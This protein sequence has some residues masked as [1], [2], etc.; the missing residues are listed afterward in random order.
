MAL[1]INIDDLLNKQKIE[2]NR[3]EFKRGWNPDKIYHTICAFATDLD[4]TG[5]GYILV[6]VEQDDNGI[7]KRP[8]KGLPLEDIDKILQDM[9]GYDAKITTSNLRSIA[10]NSRVSKEEVDGQYI[11]VIW[12]PAG[13]NRPYCVP[14]SVVAKG[15]SPLKYYIRSKASTIEARGEILDEV[16]ALAD[17]TPF[18]ERGN[19][20]IKIEDISD[21]LVYEHLKAVKSKLAGNFIGRPLMEVLDEMDLLTGPVENRS[22]KNVAAMMFSEHPEKFFPVTQVDIVIFPEGS[23][24]NPDMMIEVPKIT[25]PVPR[26]IKETLSYLRI[27]VIRKQITKPS[28]D[29]KSNKIYN[30]PYQAFEESVVNALYHRDYQEREPVEITIEP[31]HIDILSYAGPDRSIS[32]EAIKAAR[33][34]KARRY[35]NR[36]LGDFLKEL[37]LTEG[38]ATGIPT[39]QKS[40]RDNGSSPAIIDTD[41]DRTYFLMTIPCRDGFSSEVVNTLSNVEYY[42]SDGLGQILGQNA[43][44]VQEYINQCV[45]TDK[46][47]LGQILEQLFVQVWNSSRTKDNA[48]E[49]ISDTIDLLCML[50]EGP[51][52]ANELSNR[53]DYTSTKDLKRKMIS[54]LIK[55]DYITMT[56]PD[57][58]TSAKQAYKLTKKGDSL[59]NP[60]AS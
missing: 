58:P 26:M 25:G 12:V 14:E 48:A 55:L 19:D 42:N 27:N 39:I 11:L 5:G 50:Q 35:R 20:A 29:E 21:I 40:L 2:S 9:V 49:I 8:V 47:Q 28:D 33:K 34:L 1:P 23:V 30:Y 46:I 15:K 10:Y 36:R 51:L 4:N 57:K 56:N 52:S 38:R 7:A 43:V 59:F 54:P 6:G 60:E 24:E 22:I 17:R 53:L 31:D 32:S 3:I 18:D 37:D 13:P 41:D 44:Q 16:R 45:I